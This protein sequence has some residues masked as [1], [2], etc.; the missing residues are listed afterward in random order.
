[1][2]GFRICYSGG[3]ERI[4]WKVGQRRVRD[5]AAFEPEY[6]DHVSTHARLVIDGSH[7]SPSFYQPI[8]LVPIMSL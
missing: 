7:W 3:T 4:S 5:A 6:L 1:M 8:V 2:L